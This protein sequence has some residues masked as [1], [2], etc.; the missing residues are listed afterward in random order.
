M[1]K[2]VSII[3]I[4]ILILSGIGAVALPN[5]GSFEKENMIMYTLDI[6]EPV[7]TESGDFIVL[8][9]PEESSQLT[10]TGKPM[11]PVIVK[12]FTFPLGTHIDSID[13][14]YEVRSLELE[15]AI[16]PSSQ[17]IPLS[18][19]YT[20]EILSDHQLMDQSI[21][22]ST[23]LYPES[24]Y[25]VHK[26]VGL[27]NGERM[28]IVN[29]R[30]YTQYSPLNNIVLVP[31]SIDISIDYELPVQPLLAADEYDLLII[32]DEGFV[33]GLQP[34]VTHKNSIGT[35][36]I[37]ETVQDIYP[38]YNGRDEAEDIK[39]R[40]KDAIED[41]GI[42]YVLLA[43]GRK[44]Q[45]HKWIIP[46][47]TV[48]ND[49]GWEAGY[50]SDLYFA[51]IY[52]IVDNE[53]VFDDWDSNENNII[54][55]WANFVGR[56]DIMDYY[57]DVSVGRLPFR[58]ASDVKPVVD[59]IIEYET[60]VDNSWF[61]KAV[62]VSG[63]T[64]PPS[65]GG[66]K[67]WWEGELE[68]GITVGL[69][70][71][72]GFTMN[73]LW[74][75]IPGAWEDIQDVVNAINQGPG[76]VHFAGHSNPA[77]WG[78][79]P[80]DDE[81]HVYVDGIRIWDMKEFSNKGKYPMVVLG[82]CHSAQFNVSMANIISGILEYG[83]GG[84]FFNDPFRFFYMEWVPYDLCSRFVLVPNGG[85]IG[86]T[87]NTGLGY[88][89]VN[90]GWDSGLGGW[91]EPRF[92]HAYANQSIEHLGK[93]H[94]QAITDYINIIGSVNSDQIDRKTIEEWVFLGDPSIKVGGL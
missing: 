71:N 93:I 60:N 62:V 72:I 85:A 12:T 16:K 36:T 24:A 49:D 94:C 25:E 56:K 35:R 90:E 41:W 67:G 2:H 89:Y 13:V 76:F 45:T 39:L 38:A 22:S 34:L 91:I 79:H 78:N 74:L 65:R 50:E 42:E 69:L 30:C 87:G 26:G 83:I 61:K 73:K 81:D 21:Y 15:Q 32:T 4:G 18:D 47:R 54:G 88:G 77:G 43:G 33:N 70:E 80:P 5:E 55:E 28:L 7:V 82:G 29:V 48:H 57:P 17:P 63:D 31:E 3:L 59:K 14:L 58:S 20:V 11:I 10:E 66:N 23:D 27:Q 64:F 44:G 86:T 6:S 52:K 37:M 75:S 68:T 9:L 46:S 53:T 51:D 84:F 92:F 40:I 1:K 8:S 19:D